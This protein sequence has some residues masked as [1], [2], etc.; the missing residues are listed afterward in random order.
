MPRMHV[1]PQFYMLPTC[2]CAGMSCRMLAARKAGATSFLGA[3]HFW[4]PLQCRKQQRGLPFLKAQRCML[5][6]GRPVRRQTMPTFRAAALGIQ[7]SRAGRQPAARAALALVSLAACKLLQLSQKLQ[8]E[9]DRLV[10]QLLAPPMRLACPQA[11]H[12]RA[13][14]PSLPVSTISTSIP[15]EGGTQ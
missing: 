7:S 5:P 6:A 3:M 12:Y 2:A 13:C 14:S 15:H 11:H 9:V 10:L 1:L 8:D 4:W